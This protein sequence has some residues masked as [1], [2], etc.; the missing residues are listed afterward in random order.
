MVNRRCGNI[1]LSVR[2]AKIS[3]CR[4]NAVAFAGVQSRGNAD[5]RC[6]GVKRGAADGEGVEASE[7]NHQPANPGSVKRVVSRHGRANGP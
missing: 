1:W 4:R 6:R 5:V 3:G 7:P 2:A